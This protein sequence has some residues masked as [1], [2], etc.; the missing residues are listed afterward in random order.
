MDGWLSRQRE[1]DAQQ[2]TV[3]REQKKEEEGA[4]QMLQKE[5]AARRAAEQRASA[6]KVEAKVE[7]KASKA[8]AHS[9]RYS[10]LRKRRSCASS[11]WN[12]AEISCGCPAKGSAR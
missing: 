11:H 2:L 3:Q 10:P 12:Y 5:A 6:S 8:E 7:A 9:W 1:R 4:K